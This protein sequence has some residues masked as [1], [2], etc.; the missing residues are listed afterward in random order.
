MG[1]NNSKAF[2]QFVELYM[3][4][5]INMW[6]GEFMPGRWVCSVGVA[7]RGLCVCVVIATFCRFNFSFTQ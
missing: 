3:N 4:E 6:V 7:R 5:E 1:K 2:C